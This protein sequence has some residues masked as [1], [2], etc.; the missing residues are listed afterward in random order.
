MQFE[1]VKEEH[2][3]KG[4]KDYEK[5]GLPEG[6]GPSSTYDIHYN[7]KTYPPKAIIAYANI[8]ASGKEIIG[9]FNGGIGTDCFKAIERAG[10]IIKQ[11]NN[12]IRNIIT[13]Y[14]DYI[15][16]TKMRDELYKWKLLKKYRGRPNLNSKNFIDEIKSIKFGNLVYHL[17]VAVL[18]N[19]TRNKTEELRTLFKNLFNES[20]LLTERINDF[21][22]DT[23]KLYRSLGETKGHHQDERSIATYLTFYNPEKYTLY[24][25]SFYLK[26]CD[27][28]NVKPKSKN[29]K[30][31]HY[32]QLLDEFIKKYIV[33]DQELIDKVQ[34]YIPE[35]Y[36][37]SNNLLL[38]QDILYCML[39]KEKN[40]KSIIKQF[41]IQAKEG[42]LKTSLYPKT[43]R[44][45]EM[46]VSFG[47]GNPSKIPF[48]GFLK[49]P[50]TITQGIYPV[51]LFFKKIN[52]LVLAYGISETKST[53]YNWA[54]NKDLRTIDEWYNTEFNSPPYR[55]GRSFIKGI[56]D[57]NIALDEERLMT[58]LDELISEYQNIDFNSNYW[59]FQGNPKIFDVETA[60]RKKFL[61]D[62]TVSAHKDKIKIGDKVI[63]WITGEKAGCYALAE[64]TSEP[65]TQIVSN[66]N[67]FW[68]EDNKNPFKAGIKIT[69]N[70]VDHPILKE[71]LKG[72]KDFEKFNAGNQGTNFSATKT[73][74]NKLHEI[75]KSRKVNYWVLSP[76]KDEKFWKDF[77][78]NNIVSIEYD[79]LKDLSLYKS[80]NSI[81]N[82]IKNCDWYNEKNPTNHVN[83]II[84]FSKSMQIGDVIII[85]K[86]R[87]DLL[88]YGIIISDYQYDD[89][90]ELKSFR[91]VEWKQQGEWETES[92][93]AIK[94][95][96]KISDYKSENEKFNYWYEYLISVMN[97]KNES[98]NME[99]AIN[100]IFYG[101]PGTGK[102]YSLKHEYFPRY[103]ISETKMS[104]E[105]YLE[106][107]ISE[108]TWLDVIAIALIE[109][110]KSKVKDILN[111]KWVQTKQKIM[112]SKTP[113]Q[114]IWGKLGFHALESCQN[115]KNSRRSNITIFNKD[116][117]SFW[118][119]SEM[120]AKEKIPEV[121]ELIKNVDN[122]IPRKAINSKN[123][124][125][126][127][128][129]Q[130]YSYEDFIEGIKPVISESE[131]SDESELQYQIEDGIFKKLCIRADKNPTERYAIFIDEINRGNVSAIFG[132]LITLIEQD[133]RKGQ[134]NEISVK[135]PYSKASFSVPPNIDIYGTMNT[136]DRSVEALDTALRRRFSF[137]EMMPDPSLLSNKNVEGLNLE[138]ILKT[139]N[140]RI[141]ILIDRD[142]TIGHSYF[143]TVKNKNDLKRAFKDKIVPLLQEYFY[144]DYGKIGLVLGQGFVKSHSKSNNPFAKFK[145][146]GKEE[147]NRD[148]YDLVPIDDNFDIINALENLLN[149]FN[150]D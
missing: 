85:K 18:N 122:Y 15:D 78:K 129:H 29:K 137:V 1:N 98:K 63:L 56:Y 68:L 22:T 113:I 5:L 106:N 8:H 87:S 95:L 136:A 91:N 132:E 25:N 101:P 97:E 134:S 35:Y 11:K 96:T 37:G 127:T 131:T 125:F 117:N 83:C 61:T 88:G 103:A 41:L 54:Y 114:T 28:L 42:S 128:F 58:D 59:I 52:R 84:D 34:G 86:G 44:D 123:Y 92:T 24:K 45:L 144:G 124:E 77:K 115:V 20:I 140:D 150:Q 109:Q 71:T 110:G 143:M 94:T 48:I 4:I 142:H 31:V 121:Y 133:K 126:I 147:L 139:I 69:H 70:F 82:A 17:S 100:Q 33:T 108:C 36:N 120:E 40:I 14:K 73:Q 10:F 13:R 27:L 119:I 80:K 81:S 49:K 60:L 66:D 43:F 104:K 7:G 149:K 23:L 148:F 3:L 38:A 2:I 90:K 30:Y 16:E 116:E 130:S 57:T 118:E 135:L 32:L 76:G 75:S 64:V 107:L 146:E 47:Q 39:D 102:T 79:E 55:Y 50:N 12:S 51:F 21:S 145:Y 65:Q 67:Q 99:S 26:F 105:K 138:E 46:K 112:S 19:L 53:D 89:T 74:Y 6:Y 141:E 111:N 93:F 62:W 9:D 72:N